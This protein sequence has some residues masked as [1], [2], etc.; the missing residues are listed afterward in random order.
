MH[1]RPTRAVAA[2]VVVALLM[3]A[4]AWAATFGADLTREPNV[5]FDC[6][7]LPFDFGSGVNRPSQAQ[8]CT[9]SASPEAPDPALGPAGEADI[10]AGPFAVPVGFGSITAL[11]VRVGPTTGRMQFAVLS[12]R[13][14]QGSPIGC[15][16]A[17]VTPPFVP[18]PNQVTTVSAN[19]PVQHDVSAPAGQNRRIDA[20]A[21][22]ILDPAVPI[23]A[24]DTVFEANAESGP[25]VA[26]F[27]AFTTVEG[28]A[29]S[30]TRFA[31][32]VD[33]FQVLV[34]A[35]W[36]ATSAPATASGLTVNRVARLAGNVA[37]VTLRCRAATRCTGF[38]RLQ[39]RT[40]AGSSLPAP[41]TYATA[42]FGVAAGKSTVVHLNLNVAGRRAAS[43][44]GAR[45]WVNVTQGAR[46]GPSTQ[47]L[48]R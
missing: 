7:L 33:R 22:S 28:L 24:H 14:V 31:V 18:T 48:L 2:S 37:R 32:G 34:G 26:V 8:S 25:P 20:I 39:S 9:Y 13:I 45:A 15:E 10:S 5:T 38:V 47:V 3:A 46:R 42:R 40:A 6:T 21:I 17:A 29:N 1:G 16:V 11:R 19:I 12:T 43:R 4:P 41:V 35:D 27:P 44:P 23:P 36:V 30:S